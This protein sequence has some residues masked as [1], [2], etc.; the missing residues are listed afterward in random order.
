M[1][2]NTQ[3]IFK[4]LILAVIFILIIVISSCTD[5]NSSPVLC[6]VKLDYDNSRYFNDIE[7]SS[8]LTNSTLH[9]KAIYL[10]SGSSYG[11]KSGFV[12]YPDGGLILSQG[13]WRIDCKWMIGNVLIAEG[14]TR[15]IWVNLNTSS[16]IVY[17]E[18]NDGIGSFS[19]DS[20]K[21]SSDNSV[22]SVSFDLSLK[23]YNNET[24][25]EDVTLSPDDIGSVTVPGYI[26][27]FKL[28]KNNLSAGY[29]L[30]TIKVIN[31]NAQ[32]S[33]NILFTDV[34]GFIVREG[35]N[36]T[37]SGE[38][39]VKNSSSGNNK[40]IYWE[41]NPSEPVNNKI[42][43][44]GKTEEGTDR[45]SLNKQDITDKTTY[46][47]YESTSGS[48]E[49]NLGHSDE[50]SGNRI[51]TPVATGGKENNFAIDMNGTNVSVTTS[52]G[53]N[54]TIIQ[55]NE[56]VTMNLF[57]SEQGTSTEWGES[58]HTG[59]STIRTDANVK[60]NGGTINIIGDGNSQSITSGSIIFTGPSKTDSYTAIIP[61]QGALN[62]EGEGG[63]I[64]MD[65]DVTVKGLMGISSFMS[66]SR[67]SSLTNNILSINISLLNSTID[68]EAGSKYIGN[69]IAYGIYLD[70][71]GKEGVINIEL[72]GATVSAKGSGRTS[73]S[74]IRIDNFS[75]T[76]NITVKDSTLYSQV[77]NCISINNCTG[78]NNVI[79]NNA[80]LT[81]KTALNISGTDTKVLVTKDGGGTITYDKSQNTI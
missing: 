74:A 58:N 35:H 51:V 20:Y 30:L 71:G 16:I 26:N 47:V 41:D 9:Y 72:D 23:K 49:M 27:A 75:G 53:E 66:N 52:L 43:V 33:D 37:I 17:L 5:T 59:L 69:E 56:N 7:L 42:E 8:E 77:G 19:L 45:L 57:N 76:L 48:G 6:N 81:A 80:T 3:N 15:D 79:L 31:E 44:G 1:K 21:V 63:T 11:A 2:K 32:S 22:T 14:T 68:A 39:E 25:S 61:K 12:P 65:G 4:T 70:C 38:C 62:L 10:G 46:I 64:V 60:L 28:V 55:L 50:E 40:Y 29:Y 78:S 67:T 36:T 54:T 34:L 73:E 18:E 24:F 13:L